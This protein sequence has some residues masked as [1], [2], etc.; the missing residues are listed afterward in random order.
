MTFGLIQDSLAR[1][2]QKM[3]DGQHTTR[4]M[5]TVMTTQKQ[6]SKMSELG[7]DDF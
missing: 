6:G 3:E 4:S 2:L 5:E 7:N 1:S